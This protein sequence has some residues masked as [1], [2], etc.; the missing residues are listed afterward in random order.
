[1]LF[2]FS[3]ERDFCLFLHWLLSY[4]LLLCGQDSR[5]SST[6]KE[7]AFVAK[8]KIE[9][10]WE[11]SPL[12]T[13]N[14]NYKFL[15][16]IQLKPTWSEISTLWCKV[17]QQ[18]CLLRICPW[19]SRIFIKSNKSFRQRSDRHKIQRAKFYC[20]PWSTCVKIFNKYR[21]V[22]VYDGWVPINDRWCLQRWFY[23]ASL[24]FIQQRK[25][26]R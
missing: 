21:Q 18:W 12:K 5:A 26:Q 25:L 16:K 6:T 15:L 11:I 8:N 17:P 9:K 1:M 7:V 20:Q 10:S 3:R 13:R 22:L 19:F 14:R 4:S 23:S 24:S 2:F